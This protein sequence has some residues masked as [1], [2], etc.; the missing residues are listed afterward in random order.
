MIHGVSVKQAVKMIKLKHLNNKTL[1]YFRYLK[2]TN[3]L[4]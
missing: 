1:L 3:I 2:H 4:Y